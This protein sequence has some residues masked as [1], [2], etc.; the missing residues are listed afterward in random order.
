[1]RFGFPFIQSFHSIIITLFSL[2]FYC[3]LFRS[4]QMK[5]GGT[6]AAAGELNKK[7]TDTQRQLEA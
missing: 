6:A 4:S 3:A 1:M 2:F 7:L 5:A